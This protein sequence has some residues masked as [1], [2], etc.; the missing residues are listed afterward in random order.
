MTQSLLSVLRSAET[1]D[2]VFQYINTLKDSITESDL[3]DKL[4]TFSA[5]RKPLNSSVDLVISHRFKRAAD[6]L[7]R[8]PLLITEASA[9]KLLDGFPGLL[10][11]LLLNLSSF[12]TA[13]LTS[14]TR[15]HLHETAAT[16]CI[17]QLLELVECHQAM[18]AD[19]PKKFP[20]MSEIVTFAN[21]LVEGRFVAWLSGGCP[22]ELLALQRTVERLNTDL[23]AE[24]KLLALVKGVVRQKALAPS[25]ATVITL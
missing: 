24:V 23:E 15:L 4:A 22:E 5:D 7:L 12:S 1:L 13:A 11:V 19:L 6:Y 2:P 10:P 18:G 25:Q 3:L 16:L 8:N 9:I 17:R 20:D 14:A 21:V